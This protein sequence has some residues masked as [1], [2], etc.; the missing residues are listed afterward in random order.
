M[1]DVVL[2]HLARDTQ[3]RDLALEGDAL[4]RDREVLVRLCEGLRGAGLAA[5]VMFDE[6]YSLYDLKLSRDSGPTVVFDHGI[7][8]GAEWHQLFRLYLRVLEFES[9]RLVVH[10]K[11][12]ESVVDGVEELVDLLLGTGKRNVTIQRYKGLGEMNPIQLWE[13]T[14]NPETRTLLRVTIEDAIETDEIFTVLMG[15]QV[16][17]RRKFIEDN[18]LNVKNLDI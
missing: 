12:S 2:Q 8:S 1:L 5:D 9:G 13:T 18:A 10:Q 15:D 11:D 14:M 3:L 6:E 7:L 4:L 16:E 17:P